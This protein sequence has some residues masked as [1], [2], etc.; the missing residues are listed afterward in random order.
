MWEGVAGLMSSVLC[1]VHFVSLR[2]YPFLDAYV[3]YECGTLPVC[4]SYL[5][6]C[7]TLVR[8]CVVGI[9]FEEYTSHIHQ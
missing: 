2:M 6:V 5:C 3:A 8:V 4:V 1:W 9:L 7:G